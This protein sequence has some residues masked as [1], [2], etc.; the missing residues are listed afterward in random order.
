MN[1]LRITTWPT[2]ISGAD[3]NRHL[4][5][6][7]T[8]SLAAS[9]GKLAFYLNVVRV[10]RRML[11]KSQISGRFRGLPR[12]SHLESDLHLTVAKQILSYRIG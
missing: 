7:Y 1:L 6:Q 8:L 5:V 10:E 9:T 4:F 11:L 3:A 2:K 12:T